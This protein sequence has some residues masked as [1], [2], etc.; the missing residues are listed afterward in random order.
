MKK[1]M[2]EN[3]KDMFLG[4]RTRKE[5]STSFFLI[6]P[7]SEISGSVT[8]RHPTPPISSPTTTTMYRTQKT[9]QYTKEPYVEKIE[10]H[11]IKS[12]NFTTASEAGILKISK[13]E[14]FRGVY[15]D[16]NKSPLPN[17]LLDPKM[18]P[19]NKSSTSCATCNRSFSECPGHFG[20]LTLAL[21]VFNVGYFGA[22]LDILKCICKS[23]S[24]VLLVDKDR[25]DHLKKMRSS[26]MDALRK[27]R[28]KK[29]MVGKCATRTIRCFRCGYLNGKVKRVRPG[30]IILHD[31][32]RIQGKDQEENTKDQPYILTPVKVLSLFKKMED[33]VFFFFFVVCLIFYWTVMLIDI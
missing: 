20:R 10:C 25:K 28:L 32:P 26:N 2:D 17:G 19:A 12:I 1:M 3:I 13:V 15:Y 5:A 33:Q 27:N 9:M 18:G 16:V 14:V 6:A 23:C 30:L 24:H 22:I 21:P 29:K 8:G 31:R 4:K 7:H 11:R